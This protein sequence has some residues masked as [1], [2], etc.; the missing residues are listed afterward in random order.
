MSITEHETIWFPLE[1]RGRDTPEYTQLVKDTPIEEIIK[2]VQ[3][4]AETDGE[5]AISA[6]LVGE[7]NK[8]ETKMRRMMAWVSN[9]T[10]IRQCVA[11]ILEHEAN[12][13]RTVD[14]VC[15]D[16]ANG[17]KMAVNRPSA[18]SNGN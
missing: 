10:N 5:W 18:P 8:N 9:E 2:I 11:W 1:Y 4:R 3:K 7:N 12:A 16:L 14:Y 6:G 17:S 15:R 13:D